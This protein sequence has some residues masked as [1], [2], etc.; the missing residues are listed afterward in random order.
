MVEGHM[1][2]DEEEAEAAGERGGVRGG[3]R[4]GWRG[5]LLDVRSVSLNRSLAEYVDSSHERSS[6]S[7]SSPP[8]SASSSASGPP[9]DG[10]AASS[11]SRSYRS[12]SSLAPPSR[13]AD[14][15]CAL[16]SPPANAPLAA[17]EVEA[18]EDRKAWSDSCSR[19]A[20]GGA[21]A[22]GKGCEA[23]R[24]SFG[25][26]DKPDKPSGGGGKEFGGEFGAWMW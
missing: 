16:A 17:G 4:G 25:A 9:P 12:L 14:L 19:G 8:G 15:P 3:W 13:P 20:S 26:K 21:S 5:D 22:R 1:E 7:L 2:D 24:E 10:S 6:P 23:D 11:D 18:G